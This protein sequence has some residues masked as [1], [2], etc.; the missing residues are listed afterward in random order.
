MSTA[1]LESPLQAIDQV[2]NDLSMDPSP[3]ERRLSSKDMLTHLGTLCEGYRCKLDDL[4]GPFAAMAE[5][6][7]RRGMS[8]EF[9]CSKFFDLLWQTRQALA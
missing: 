5:A 9:E 8:F 2:L 7:H 3:T 6:A 4:P 1:V